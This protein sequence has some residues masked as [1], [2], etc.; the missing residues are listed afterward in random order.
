MRVLLITSS[1]GEQ[2]LKVNVSSPMLSLP[3]V[4]TPNSVRIVTASHG[5]FV[6]HENLG[7]VMDRDWSLRLGQR[8][9][10]QDRVIVLLLID[11]TTTATPDV[12]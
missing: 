6:C 3:L 2:T 10:T 1:Y 11:S 12:V 9:W 5:P 7:V 4:C 8:T